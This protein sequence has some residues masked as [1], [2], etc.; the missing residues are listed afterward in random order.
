[1]N[2]KVL[3][4][5]VVVLWGG[6]LLAA[7]HY[8]STKEKQK[9]IEKDNQR[10]FDISVNDYYVAKYYTEHN[11][12]PASLA[13]VTAYSQEESKNVASP[14]LKDPDKKNYTYQAVSDD[15]YKICSSFATDTLHNKNL[16]DDYTQY[17]ASQLEKYAK[18]VY[19]KQGYDCIEI[20]MQG[21]TDNANVASNADAAPPE[22]FTFLAPA[23][24]E[25]VCLGQDYR[26]AWEGDENTTKV[27]IYLIPPQTMNQPQ[28]WIQNGYIA[29][30]GEVVEMATSRILEGSMMWKV[31]ALEKYVE[32]QTPQPVKPGAGY[33]LGV[34]TTTGGTQHTY[35]SDYFEISDCNVASA[36]TP[37]PQANGGN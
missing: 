3:I 22:A 13:D 33:Q 8:F 23:N 18:S 19:H 17:I 12:L 29:S 1:V 5:I 14:V 16:T 11:T 4:V 10:L 27:G 36:T 34:V 9:A 32:A 25:K 35:S 26:L 7:Y 15:T 31:G 2:K 6:V 20:S 28:S 24:N 37:T 30:P 21:N